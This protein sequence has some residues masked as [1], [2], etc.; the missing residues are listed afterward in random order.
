[1]AQ[2][3]SRAAG[4]VALG[5]SIE[6]TGPAAVLR[7]PR[8]GYQAPGNLVTFPFSF[9]DG[10]PV[11]TARLNGGV[12]APFIFDTGAAYTAL[13]GRTA[14]RAGVRTVRTNDIPVRNVHGI[15]G[16][17]HSC[18]GLLDSFAL[19]AL[20]ITNMPVH[21]RLEETKA[22]SR[23]HRGNSLLGLVP[24]IAGFSYVTIDYPLSLIT[25]APREEFRPSGSG[26]RAPL[27]L[28]FVIKDGSLRVMLGLPKGHDAEFLVD[29]GMGGEI[30]LSMATIDNAGLGNIHLRS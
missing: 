15:G 11:V 30:C 8:P 2:L 25:V 10:W 17:E 6:G 20:E 29:T 21:V 9:E 26:T 5:F 16:M 14:A 22:G 18:V 1:M 19:G 12:T 27:R 23:R 24:A 3:S 4:A 28:P 7:G 13:E